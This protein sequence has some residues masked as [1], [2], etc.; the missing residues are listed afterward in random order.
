MEKDN[1]I[2]AVSTGLRGC[3]FSAAGATSAGASAGTSTAAST[4]SS[5]FGITFSVTD[6]TGNT[7][8]GAGACG[9]G[10]SAI[11]P[12]TSGA[13]GFPTSFSSAAGTTQAAGMIKHIATPIVEP[14]S[15][16]TTSIDGMSKPN[17]SAT[18]TIAIVSGRNLDSGMYMCPSDARLYSSE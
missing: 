4:G 15:P 6:S 13:G 8:G 3:C 7:G 18:T 14:T 10:S 5:I 16:I 1:Q 12:G 9:F 17:T 11:L 2:A